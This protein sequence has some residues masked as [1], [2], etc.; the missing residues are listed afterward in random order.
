MNMIRKIGRAAAAA[1]LL[2]FAGP[3]RAT[4]LR[5]AFGE[6]VIKNIKIGQTYSMYKLLNLPLRVVN[7]GAIETDLKIEVVKI[8]KDEL[9]PG[10][11][12]LGSLDWVKL[13]QS[14]FTVA[15]NH[16]AVTDLTISI[17]NDPALL[18]RRFEADILSQTISRQGT[19]AVA[20]LSR[21]LIHVDSTPPSEDELKKK[22][23]DENVANLDFTVIPINAEVGDIALGRVVDLRKERKISI[24]LINPNDRAVSFRVRSIPSWESELRPPT[25]Y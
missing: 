3:A 25:G 21:L 23:V 12:P 19:Y 15:P 7:T 10:Y 16:E 5:T 9:R 22:F 8:P 18:G 13:A 24:K 1:A 2:A 4:G 20:L 6:V 17:P 11:D 14:S